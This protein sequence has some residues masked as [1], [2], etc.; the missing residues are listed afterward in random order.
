MPQPLINR[1]DMSTGANLAGPRLAA[2]SSGAR[3]RVRTDRRSD[4]YL[5]A[6]RALDG[7]GHLSQVDIQKLVDDIHREFTEKYSA[8][9]IGI[10]GK[11]YLGEPFEVHTLALDGSIIE[12]YR[13]GQALPGGMERARQMAISVAYQAIEVYTDRMV[14][15]R[16]DGS[17]V[18]LESGA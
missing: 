1:K 5:R 11:C 4:T 14:C 10:V 9:P 15:V 18:A 8:T 6:I 12:H 3:Q 17:V 2:A 16:A 7:S 13:V